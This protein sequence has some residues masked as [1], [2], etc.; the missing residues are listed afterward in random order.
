MNILLCFDESLNFLVQNWRID[1][2]IR[3]WDVSENKL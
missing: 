1:L 3:F 2:V